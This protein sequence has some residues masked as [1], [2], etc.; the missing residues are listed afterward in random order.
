MHNR[1]QRAQ[2][3][4]YSPRSQKRIRE[5]ELERL[6]EI[7][8]RKAATKFTK[9]K[10]CFRFFDVDKDGTVSREEVRQFFRFM[11]YQDDTLADKF[12]D[13]LDVDGSGEIDHNE[14][15]VHLGPHI[16]PGYAPPRKREIGA[17]PLAQ[18][19][20]ALDL[21]KNM[22]RT[23][24]ADQVAGRETTVKSDLPSGYSGHVP[25]LR[26]GALFKN[27]AFYDNSARHYHD[28][29]THQ[30]ARDA[31]PSFKDQ[32]QGAP[33]AIHKTPGPWSPRPPSGSR[34]GYTPSPPF[35]NITPTPGPAERS[36]RSAMVAGAMMGGSMSAR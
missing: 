12:F 1:P 9:V 6:S 32:K 2:E 31:F 10:D 7:I 8:G 28:D 20:A 30:P 22:Y 23:S 3:E 19:P 14:L 17:N 33:S 15:S 29:R 21:A 5:K 11:N 35:A 34:V 4:T 18:H 36:N 27:T 26:H 13:L 25:N 24:Y 16:Q